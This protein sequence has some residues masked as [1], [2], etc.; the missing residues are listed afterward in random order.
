MVSKGVPGH[1]GSRILASRGSGG[2]CGPL[3][4][5]LFTLGILRMGSCHG[6]APPSW[7]KH[8]SGLQAFLM[9]FL[10]LRRWCHPL[11][12]SQGPGQAPSAVRPINHPVPGQS[13][14]CL[15]VLHAGT[16]LPGGQFG[17]P[18]SEARGGGMSAVPAC[19]LSA[20]LPPGWVS[21]SSERRRLCEPG[22]QED[23]NEGAGD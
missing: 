20:D 1:P 16:S 11:L 19:G 9:L 21:F 13:G 8:P 2:P 18:G 22:L 6:L 5:P 15:L 12:L 4:T 10:C 3:R 23:Q 7:P 17:A 14:T